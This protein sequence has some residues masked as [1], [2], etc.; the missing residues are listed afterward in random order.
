MTFQQFLREFWFPLL[1]TGLSVFPGYAAM[2]AE[3]NAKRVWLSIIGVILLVAW[4]SW[5]WGDPVRGP[6]QKM[7]SPHSQD[8]FRLN[9]MGFKTYVPIAR[10]S[11]GMDFSGMFRIPGNPI[12][13]RIR[14]TWWSGRHW[15]LQVALSPSAKYTEIIRD[16][17]VSTE[18]PDG[19]DVNFDDHAVELIDRDNQPILQ[20][21]QDGDYDVYINAVLKNGSHSAMVIR[22]TRFTSLPESSVTPNDFPP[23]LFKYPGYANRG[24]R[25]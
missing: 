2:A 12:K 3:G 11:D 19:Y 18:V 8:T 1:L 21:I 25:M 9:A 7:I 5:V 22:G 14:K 15:D 6:F 23:P 24:A 17:Q 16:N 10:L 13:L 20:V 4:L